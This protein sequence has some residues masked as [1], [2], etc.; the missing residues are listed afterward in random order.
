[1]LL[2]KQDYHLPWSLA[3]CHTSY[4]NNCR[5][6]SFAPCLPHSLLSTSSPYLLKA[7]VQWPVTLPS[8]QSCHLILVL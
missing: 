5:I 4:C 1:M 2:W 3:H 8:L 6:P 7:E